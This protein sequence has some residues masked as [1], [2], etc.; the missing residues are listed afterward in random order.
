M[1]KII[2]PNKKFSGKRAGVPFVDGVG[3][4]DDESAVRYFA[5]HG[6]E[7]EGDT[8]AP[9]PDVA[10][11]AGDK[12]KATD[13]LDGY[14]VDELRDYAEQHHI[15]LGDASKKADIRAVID[16]HNAVDQP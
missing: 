14:T 16:A 3:Q 8:A 2:A 4:T 12:D 1:A 5:K 10:G 9:N 11:G 6:Y 13:P 7:V 15:D